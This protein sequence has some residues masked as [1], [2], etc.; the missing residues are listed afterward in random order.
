MSLGYDTVSL[1]TRYLTKIWRNPTLMATNLATPLL[2]LV[3]FSQLLTKLSEFPGVTGNYLTF[4]TPGVLIFNAM[5]N[6]PQSGVSIANDLNSGFLSKMMVTRANRPALLIG[7]LLT[8]VVMVTVG[9]ILVVIVAVVM[10]VT[11]VTGAPGVLLIIVTVAFFQLAFSGLFLAVGMK[12]RQAETISAISGGLFFILVFISSAMFPTAFFP[13]WAQTI[14]NYN[15]VS[16][17][18]NVLRDLVQ[19]GLTWSVVV[20]AYAYI[21]AI[22]L[23]TVSATLYM[24]RK[25]VS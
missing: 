8:D 5:I 11:F 13:S 14:S 19:G 9:T 18:A 22:T 1:L 3:L 21:G 20:K 23:V 16:Y 12:T 7:R 4:L 15:P 17:G 24:F 10:G 25:V 6:A 2:F